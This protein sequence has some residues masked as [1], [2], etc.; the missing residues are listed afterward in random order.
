MFGVLFGM[1]IG[2]IY[3]ISKDFGTWNRKYIGYLLLGIIAGISISFLEPARENNNLIF[4]FFCG[5][6]SVSGMTLPGL[7]GSFIL[8]LIGNYVLLLVDSVNALYDTIADL[9]HWNFE[10]LNNTE[11]IQLLKVLLV[12][13]LGSLAGLVTFSH[14]LAYVLKHFRKATYAVIIGFITGSLGVVWPW[15]N[16]EFELDALGNIQLDAD[17]REI[18]KDYDRYWPSEFSGETLWAIFFI[19][20]GILIVVSLE[21]YNKKQPKKMVKYGLVGKHIDYSFSKTFFTE[22]FERE[23]LK[24][25][26]ENFDL[27]SIEELQKVLKI[28][29]LRGLNVTI[30]YKEAI[31][32]Y[33]DSLDEEA[34]MIG[35][36]NTIKIKKN[37]NLKGYNTD[38]FGFAKALE[39]FFPLLKK[40]PWYWVRAVLQKP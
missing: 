21:R 25:T 18:I 31:I 14:I 6:I 2:S 32:P 13:S 29:G 38:H 26:Y 37:G 30:P 15:K 27:D 23:K 5:M 16:K 20:V 9:L 19:I 39:G 3:Y 35:A 10:F 4:V 12:F 34:E 22:K 17:G 7:S 28:K 40:L 36:V 24:A 1:I 11:R 33:L 8:I